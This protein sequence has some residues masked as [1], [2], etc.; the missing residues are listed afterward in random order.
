QRP[1]RPACFTIMF[2]Y[3]FVQISAAVWLSNYL[4]K[5]IN[6]RSPHQG[7]AVIAS[8]AG[9]FAL[10]LPIIYYN[11]KIPSF[12]LS[13][14]RAHA[15]KFSTR[16]TLT[17]YLVAF[18]AMNALGAIAFLFAGFTQLIFS[19]VKVKWML[20]MLFG[21]QAILKKEMRNLF[22][23]CC[24]M[25][26][27]IGLF[28]YFSD[29]KTIILFVICIFITFI[30][31]VKI[32]HILLMVMLGYFFVMLGLTWTTIK[33]EYREYLNQGTRTQTKQVSQEEA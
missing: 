6:Y 28:S 23:V 32:R 31:V 4:G 14:L 3:H 27:V 21:Y 17:A 16:K 15:Y 22:A 9:L 29:F 30:S 11:N 8:Y 19:L 7:V 13:D 5:D 24:G 10:F 33:G 20:L 12:N 26:F 1:Y 18:F 25:E 2:V